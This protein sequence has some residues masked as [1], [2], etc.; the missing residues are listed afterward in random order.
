M[1]IPSIKGTA[2]SSAHDDVNAL[3]AR[4]AV[5]RDELEIGLEA[6]DLRLLDQK[7]LPSTW[8]PIGTYDRLLRVLCDK[9][10]NGAVEAYLIARGQKAGDRIA[11]TG[12][13]QQLD[14]NTEALGVRTG[15]VVVTIAGLIFNFTRWQFE[16]EGA[17]VGNFSIRVEEAT[18]FPEAAR[19]T[20]Q[21]FIQYAS[22]R[23][24]GRPMVATSER[25]LASR[26]LFHVDHAR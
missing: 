24:V 19:F 22:T 12:I 26:I 18:D 9:E 25:A 13:Y 8:Y 16:R 20:T 10:A 1:T 23:I 4:G 15:R 7:V 21:G 3:L 2:F 11:A 6:E 14:T 17:T 5:G